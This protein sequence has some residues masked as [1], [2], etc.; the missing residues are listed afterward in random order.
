MAENFTEE[1][2]EAFKNA[3]QLLDR[4]ENGL[5]SF[6]KIGFL[7]RSV[8][9][10]PS[11]SKMNDIINDLHDANGFERGR[12]IDFTDFLLIMSK[13]RH[14][15]EGHDLADV[16]K[17]FDKEATGIMKT[18]E[19]K[20]VLEILQDDVIQD[21]IPEML[22]DFDL[23]GDGTISFEEFAAVMEFNKKRASAHEPSSEAGSTAGDAGKDIAAVM[24]IVEKRA[25][26]HE[27][28][29]GSTTEEAGTSK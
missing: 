25:S 14:E 13:I 21:E 11:E 20:M 17:V 18:D 22:A 1:E 26:E 24:E 29:S 15:D 23:N 10:N 28:N 4:E 7:L 2:I 8:G 9:E 12:W 5:V 3:F 6:K 19:L 16:F 27:T